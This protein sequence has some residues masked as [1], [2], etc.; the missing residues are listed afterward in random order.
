MNTPDIDS[1]TSPRSAVLPF[2]ALGTAAI[3]FAGLLSAALARVASY[4]SAWLVAYLVLIVG[5]AQVALGLGQWWLASKRLSPGVIAGEL[6]VF[7]LG[8]AGVILG[9][10]ISAPIWV[11]A[12]SV[13]IAIALAWF[14][15]SVWRPRKRGGALWAYWALVV[16]LLVSVIVGLFLAHSSA[17]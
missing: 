11:D 14:G 13:L 6:V 4:H 15:W 2:F 3:I 5:V 1:P 7:N 12:G 8:N 17:A 16:L 10:L 9:T